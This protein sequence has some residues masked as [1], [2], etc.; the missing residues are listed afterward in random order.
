MAPAKDRNQAR[1]SWLRVFHVGFV[2]SWVLRSVDVGSLPGCWDQAV[3]AKRS[4]M[5]AGVLCPRP[6][7]FSVSW[8]ACRVMQ[9]LGLRV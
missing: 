5:N 3:A 1:D 4:A 8:S 2:S 6:S 9:G 7:L